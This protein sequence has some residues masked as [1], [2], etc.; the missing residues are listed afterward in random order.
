M[1]LY[2]TQ[3]L[4]CYEKVKNHPRIIIWTNM[5][6]LESPML[7]IPRFSLKVFLV[8]EKKIFL[9]YMGMAAI[10]FNGVEPFQ[11]TVNIASTEGN[12]VK[13]GEN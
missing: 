10:L 9:T 11:K 3:I 8:L 13:S 7:Y 5:L 4:F 1:I 12:R 2:G 6:D